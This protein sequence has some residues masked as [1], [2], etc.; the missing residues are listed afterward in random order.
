[1]TSREAT[2]S[3]HGALTD[4]SAK[5]LS[6]GMGAGALMLTVMAFSA[7]IVV[8]EGLIPFAIMFDGP[9]ASFAFA[10]TTMLLL[11][12]SVGYVTLARYVRKPG[13][14]YAFVSEGLG[15]SIGLGAAFM[16]IFSYFGLLAGTYVFLGVN[17]SSMIQ[18]FGGGAVPWPVFAIIGWICV[19]ALGHFHI[20]LSAKVLSV[21]MVIEVLIVVIYDVAV[22]GSGGADGLHLQPFSPS[23]FGA[24]AIAPTMLYTILVFLGFE[25][26][27]LF[28]NEVRDPDRTIP[29]ATYGAVLLVGII[30]TV[31][32]YALVEAHGAKAWDVAK[33]MPTTMFVTSIGDYVSPVFAQ[34]TYCAVT[35][36]VLAAL[37]SIHNVLARYVY[38]LA[39]DH[40]L[41]RGLGKVHARHS[42][43]HLASFAVAIVVAVAIAPFILQ[44]FDGERLY[45]I[46]AGLGGLGVIF[47]MA[48]VSTAVV[49]WFLRKG[50]P[51]GESVV[52]TF[53]C[54]AL[55]GLVLFAIFVF[56]A[57]HMDY[58]VGGNAASD[59]WLVGLLVASFVVGSLVALYYRSGRPHVFERLGGTERAFDLIARQEPNH[60]TPETAAE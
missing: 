29:R 35:T 46:T 13:D 31:T 14:F 59:Y 38:N 7:P 43:P 2:G 55:V 20:E 50:V 9:G 17:V 24:G 25:A 39:V 23:A 22:L 32:C 51:A 4:G 49:V 57:M 21:A 5:R 42:S 15:K 27:A 12:F 30:Y 8:V 44:G 52:K 45:T 40:A 58:V 41:P 48:L 54:P 26:T 10:L 53:V 16:A 3:R 37:I 60:A 56:A 33:S 28:R 1:M 36:S 18:S 19:S 47:L 34:V 11:L 6:G